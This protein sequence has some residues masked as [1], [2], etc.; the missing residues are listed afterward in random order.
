MRIFDS[1]TAAALAANRV[2]LHLLFWIVARN[3]TTGAPEALGLWTGLQPQ[4]FTVAG[5]PRVYQGVGN[6]LDC[7]PIVMEPGYSV[8]SLRLRLGGLNAAAVNALRVYD[9]RLAPVQL[10]RA[11]FD[12]ETMGLVAAPHQLFRGFVDEAS[13]PVPEKNGTATAE[14]T[15][16]SSALSG[17]RTLTL[18]KS[19]EAL[20]ARAPGDGFRRYISISNAVPVWWGEL[21]AGQNNAA[22]AAPQLPP[23]RTD[24][25]E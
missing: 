22:R 4:T 6:A 21:R 11:V 5:Q 8:R 23:G 7:D 18:R 16:A 17:T 3:R 10:H 14:V 20:R 15:L 19:D 9:A 12:P 2:H 24:E 1:A 13:L 25:R